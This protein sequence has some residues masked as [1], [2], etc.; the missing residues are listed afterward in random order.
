MKLGHLSKCQLVLV[1]LFQDERLSHQ[2]QASPQERH[3]RGLLLYP[4]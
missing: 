1:G 2:E 4:Q 3:N